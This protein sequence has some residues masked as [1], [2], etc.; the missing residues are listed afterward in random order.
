[1]TVAV[2]D[3]FP[4]LRGKAGMGAW[5]NDAHGHDCIGYDVMISGVVQGHVGRP[6]YDR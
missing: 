1:M 5:E 4:R 3:T 6:E 2:A